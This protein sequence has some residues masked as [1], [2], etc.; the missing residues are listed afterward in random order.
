METELLAQIKRHKGLRNHAY[1]DH[2]GYLTI[3]YG[4]LID[5]RRGGRITDEEAEFL[6]TSDVVACMRDMGSI[7]TY[8]QL[9]PV[10]QAALVNMRFKLGSAGIR[11]FQLMWAAL[12]RYDYEDAA[13]EALDSKWAGQT[14]IRAN[15][16]AEQLRT[17]EW[18]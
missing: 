4:R 14:P 3:G 2:L 18:Q 16:V 10:R 5:E 15:E 8:R 1:P 9:D 6:L 13:A 7:K 11:E 12:E 17:G